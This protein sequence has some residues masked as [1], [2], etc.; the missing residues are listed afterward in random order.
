MKHVRIEKITPKIALKLLEGNNVNRPISDIRVQDFSRRMRSG[1]WI[2]SSDPI[3]IGENGDLYN[4]QTRLWAICDSETDQQFFV[5]RDAPEDMLPVIDCGKSRTLHDR[6]QIAGN[7]NTGIRYEAVV[8]CFY[9]MPSGL[10]VDWT[11]ENF[12]AAEKKCRQHVQFAAEIMKTQ[13]NRHRLI[14]APYQAAMARAHMS[15]ISP[16][17][18]NGFANVFCRDGASGVMSLE[19]DTYVRR[20]KTQ[21]L[22]EEQSPIQKTYQAKC[23]LFLAKAIKMFSCNE[24]PSK[25]YRTVEDP[26]PLRKTFVNFIAPFAVEKPNRSFRE[27]QRKLLEGENN[28]G[29]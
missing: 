13:D 6:L 18:L 27:A 4:G 1:E 9:T 17:V 28:D 12:L 21:A 20:I 22:L 24:A 5:L 26:F 23:Y 16:D 3:V 7:R 19:A 29:K 25:I 2:L 8:K 14:C 10:R 11:V 15:E